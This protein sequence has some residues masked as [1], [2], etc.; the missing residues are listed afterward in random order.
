MGAFNYPT[1]CFL[2]YAFF[3]F[4]SFLSSRSDMQRKPKFL[5]DFFYF[6]T[7]IS[8]IEA[9]VLLFLLCWFR[10]LDLN[11]LDSISGK[12]HIMTISALSNYAKRNTSSI[13]DD[14]SFCA[15]FCP[16]C[17]IGPCFFSH[18]EVIWSLLHP[19]LT[20]TNQCL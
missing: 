13:S 10:P 6:I 15:S 18:R 11:F 16:V 2:P 9:E 14:A 17:R 5:S 8:C 3:E 7:N 4:F 19:S 20:K 1:A 12:L